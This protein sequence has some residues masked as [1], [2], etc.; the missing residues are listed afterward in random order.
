VSRTSFVLA[1]AGAPAS[2]KTTLARNLAATTAA[3]YISFGDLVRYEAD[4]QHTSH[5]RSNLQALGSGML[6]DLGPRGLCERALEIA[7]AT[8]DTRPVIWDGVRHLPVL[9]EL[10]RLYAPTELILVVLKP[11]EHARRQR[12][13]ERASSPE[14]LETWEADDTESHL[15]QLAVNAQLIC[16]AATPKNA[17]ARILE[18]LAKEHQSADG[19]RISHT[20]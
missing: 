4:A 18:L 16:D 13:A 19:A 9:D 7:R 20:K 8:S 12:L 5:D 2:G 14:Q 10:R 11:P 17:T 1:L 15:A 3:T 6:R